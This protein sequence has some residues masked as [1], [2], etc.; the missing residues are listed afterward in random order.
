MKRLIFSKLITIVNYLV[1]SA[2][3]TLSFVTKIVQ[4]TQGQI[5][6]MWYSISYQP[7]YVIKPISVKILFSCDVNKYRQML[8]I[9]FTL[10][11]SLIS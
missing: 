3:E 2:T 7:F 1:C 10:Y 5:I 9:R 6:F 11:I 4:L 8:V